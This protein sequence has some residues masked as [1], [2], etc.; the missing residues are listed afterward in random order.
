MPGSPSQDHGSPHHDAPDRAETPPVIEQ[1]L[2]AV[3]EMTHS[4]D[5]ADLVKAYRRLSD[6]YR[7]GAGTARR[8]EPVDVLAYATARLPATLGATSA[9]LEELGNLVPTW[10]PRT[11]GDLGAGLGSAG[12]LGVA[13]F[14][15]LAEL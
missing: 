13:I 7:S 3:E 12:W 4:V 9:G 10:R 6:R 2:Q 1:M 15:T 11:A 5:S 8:L 14:P